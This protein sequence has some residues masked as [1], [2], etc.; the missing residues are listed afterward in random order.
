MHL[1]SKSFGMPKEN[2]IGKSVFELPEAIPP[3][4]ADMYNEQD[5]KLFRELDTQEYEKQVQCSDGEKRDFFFTKA[6]FKNYTGDV[7]GIVGV[8]L[9]VTKRKQAELSLESSIIRQKRL[10]RL[11][12]DLL[13]PAKLEQK[14]KM[15]SDG[16]VEIFGAD[17]CRIWIT[18]PGDLCEAG[19]KHA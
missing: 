6:T 1:P 12:S 11:Q 14:L 5:Q 16:V 2:I 19:C 3:D 18:S 17:F 7:A 15:I 13:A 4:L 10:N 9:D 8:M